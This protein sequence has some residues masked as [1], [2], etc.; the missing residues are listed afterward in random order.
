MRPES[1]SAA[2]IDRQKQ[3]E[4]Q[5]DLDRQKQRQAEEREYQRQEIRD[6]EA[7]R[8]A[9][10]EKQR[11]RYEISGEGRQSG[12][13]LIIGNQL[14]NP[15]PVS[16]C[17]KHRKFY[18]YLFSHFFYRYYIFSEFSGR[19]GTEE[20]THNAPIITQKATAR[21]NEREEG[22]GGTSTPRTREIKGGGESS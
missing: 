20:G 22:S 5:R 1:P 10:R 6:K 18:R 8:G 15:D 7:I 17:G 3:L 14:A 21:G 16:L 9:E 13:G 4:S 12:V 19:N 11:E 2:A